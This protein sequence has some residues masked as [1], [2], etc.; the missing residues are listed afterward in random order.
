MFYCL[1]WLLESLVVFM[2]GCD[3]LFGDLNVFGW[4]V[5]CEED[6]DWDV[7]VWI[8]IIVDMQLF[9]VEFFDQVLVDYGCIGFV[10]GVVIVEGVEE[11]FE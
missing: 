1:Y 4:F 10:E 6:V 11:E 8:L 3:V 5:C 7:V 2:I 9:W